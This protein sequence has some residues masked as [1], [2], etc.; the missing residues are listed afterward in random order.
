VSSKP[1][2]VDGSSWVGKTITH[3]AAG[4]NN[5]F[6]V[7]SD[8]SVFAWGDGQQGQLGNG[9][10]TSATSPQTAPSLVS[11]S[12]WAGKTITQIVGGL[13]TGYSLASDGSVYA[14]GY[15]NNGELGNGATATKATPVPVIA[16]LVVTGKFLHYPVAGLAPIAVEDDAVAGQTTRSY[17]V[18]YLEGA[19][20]GGPG[21]GESR[22]MQV[23]ARFIQPMSE[24]LDDPS[25]DDKVVVHQAWLDSSLTP[26]AGLLQDVTLLED[27]DGPLTVPRAPVVP[28]PSE[29][30]SLGVP[31]NVTCNTDASSQSPEDSCDQVP[32]KLPAIPGVPGSLSGTAWVDTDRDGVRDVYLDE[33][34]PDE[35]VLEGVTVTLLRGGAVYGKTTTT[36]EDGTYRFDTVPAGKGYQVQ[37]GLPRPGDDSPTAYA[38]T[39]AGGGSETNGSDIVETE[40]VIEVGA[41]GAAGLTALLAGVGDPSESAADAVTGLTGLLE[42]KAGE[43]TKADVGVVVYGPAISVVKSSPDVADGG[44]TSV[45]SPYDPADPGSGAPA[46]T[47]TATFSNIGDEPLTNIAW[48]DVTGAGP[49]V[50]GWTCDPGIAPNLVLQPAGSI[51]C[52][53]TLPNRGVGTHTDTVT[54]TAS[55]AMTSQVVSDDSAFTLATVDR[56]MVYLHK[57][58]TD[59]ANLAGASFVLY[60]DEDGT[61]DGGS[62]IVV[63]SVSDGWF[64]VALLDGDYWLTETKAPVGHE[65][66]A[67][68]VAFT[69]GSDG[70]VTIGGTTGEYPQV[71][72]T[73]TFGSSV[74]DTLQVADVA[75]FKL[76]WAGGPG[77]NLI[78]DLAGAFLAFLLAGIIAVTMRRTGSPGTP[79]HARAV[80]G[81]AGR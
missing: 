65:L 77:F 36:G 24:D 56:H 57:T 19:S 3:I 29:F 43:E 5:A 14:W 12:T 61:P 22:T 51:T 76:P 67:A 42:V 75:A 74:D 11:G 69:V 70:T 31:G 41:I 55:G 49:E 9:V 18:G 54:V 28:I 71:S 40:N 52:T 66:L 79:H 34:A 47:V 32:A 63:A 7:A 2:Q 26:I 6:A 25:A 44:Q 73:R 59:G 72:V 45:V 17:R 48:A 35:P 81:R 1:V 33:S 64:Q 39:Q 68:R 78:E 58:G 38:F 46:V 20:A 50:T 15:G 62:P 53:G 27:E 13:Y 16:P 4:A 60:P 10:L 80:Q 37:F 30:D 23:T 8:G 21:F